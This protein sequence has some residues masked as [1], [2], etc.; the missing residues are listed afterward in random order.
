MIHQADIGNAGLTVHACFSG[1]Y[2]GYWYDPRSL[3]FREEL[4]TSISSNVY[5]LIGAGSLLEKLNQQR[6][7]LIVYA[8]P[9][10]TERRM[11]HPLGNPTVMTGAE[12]GLIEWLELAPNSAYA[13]VSKFTQFFPGR[14]MTASSTNMVTIAAMQNTFGVSPRHEPPRR[15]RIAGQ[16]IRPGAVLEIALDG[17]CSDPYDIRLPLYATADREDGN[18]V[19]TTAVEA[20]ALVYY[21]WLTAG[22]NQ[23]A[24]RVLNQDGTSGCV[25]KLAM[26]LNDWP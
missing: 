10:G 25:D 8:T 17:D 11:A 18:V 22:N 24:A 6:D 21:G 3:G 16:F 13:D 7:R 15:L 26:K 19:W 14:N 4:S 23:H 1:D 20:D 5:P 9:L 2:H 12:P